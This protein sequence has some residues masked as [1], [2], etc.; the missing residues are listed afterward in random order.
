MPRQQSAFCRSSSARMQCL[1]YHYTLHRDEE[2]SRHPPHVPIMHVQA[3]RELAAALMEGFLA[4][5]EGK[6]QD[7]FP[8]LLVSSWLPLVRVQCQCHIVAAAQHNCADAVRTQFAVAGAE[9]LT[10][11]CAELSKSVSVCMQALHALCL[12]DVALCMPPQDAAKYVRCL[13]PYLKV[14]PLTAGPRSADKDRR[15]AACLLC[16]LV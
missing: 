16:K 11:P 12:T 5:S 7:T 3:G 4:A 9:N 1:S 15:D 13:A 8:H 2:K 14:A 6:D 10:H